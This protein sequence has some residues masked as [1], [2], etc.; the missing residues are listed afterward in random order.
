MGG[1]GVYLEKGRKGRRAEDRYLGSCARRQARR[2]RLGP[3]RGS[4]EGAGAGK[5][6]GGPPEGGGWAVLQ[7]ARLWRQSV[8]GRWVLLC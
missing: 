7:G 5:E 4:R 6:G 8:A 1:A 3:G 2:R